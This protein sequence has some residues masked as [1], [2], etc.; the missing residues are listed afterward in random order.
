[1]NLFRRSVVDWLIKLVFIFIKLVF[2]DIKYFVKDLFSNINI[3]IYFK[4]FKNF[5]W[6]L[7]IIFKFLDLRLCGFEFYGVF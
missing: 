1:M 4:F 7:N 5:D 2:V 3:N 6:V